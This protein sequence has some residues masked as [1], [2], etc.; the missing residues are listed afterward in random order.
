MIRRPPRSTRTDTLFPYTTLFRSIAI[1]IDARDGRVAVEGWAETA[2]ITAEALALKFED[3]GAAAIVF[4]DIDRD[5]ALQ[6]PNLAATA[7][8]ARRL[9]TPVIASGGVS[10]PDDLRALAGLAGPGLS[11]ALAP[12][13]HRGGEEG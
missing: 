8:L 11:G 3:A 12:E 5:G 9:S 7:A 13:H 6:G 1:G 2:E 10:S 4:T